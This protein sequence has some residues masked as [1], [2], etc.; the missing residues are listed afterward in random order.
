[1][2]RFSRAFGA[3]ERQIAL[4]TGAHG[5]RRASAPHFKR[6]RGHARDAR[7]ARARRRRLGCA[8]VLAWGV[9]DDGELG[10][11]TTTGPSFCLV[12]KVEHSCSPSP[13]ASGELGE[14]TA[15]AAGQFARLALL[16]TGR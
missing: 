5:R 10:D 2:G 12:S 8:G 16:A 9:N 11:G 15:V 6:K 3:A 7:L 14:V 4:R 1:M 13:V